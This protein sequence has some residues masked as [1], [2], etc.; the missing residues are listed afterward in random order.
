MGI[1]QCHRQNNFGF[2]FFKWFGSYFL[3]YKFKILYQHTYTITIPKL[4]LKV[5]VCRN[6]SIIIDGPA[7]LRRCKCVENRI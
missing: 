2:R 4:M 5:K 3:S 1:I 6:G 7:P